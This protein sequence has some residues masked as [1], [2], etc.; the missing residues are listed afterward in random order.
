MNAVAATSL[1][2]RPS[3]PGWTPL[4][5]LA[6]AN[7]ARTQMAWI[8]PQFDAETINR[9]GDEIRAAGS[10][11][12]PKTLEIV[13]NWRMAHAFPL[14]TVKASLRNNCF[15]VDKR[16]AVVSRIKRFQTIRQKLRRI[17]KLTL[18]EMQDLGGAR[19]IF[20][21]CASIDRLLAFYEPAAMR[22]AGYLS[23]VIRCNNYIN[24]PK[25]DGYR[26][27][28]LIFRYKGTKPV[29]DGLF[30]EAQVR[31]QM[32][33]AWATTVEI[34]ETILKQR[35]RTSQ[36]DASWK[37]FLAL[38][39]TAIALEEKRPPVPETPPS[40]DEIRRDILRI[41]ASIHVKG[42]LRGV[43]NAIT[44]APKSGTGSTWTVLDMRPEEDKTSVFAFPRDSFAQ[45]ARKLAD[46]EKAISSGEVEDPGANAVL[47][48]VPS[49]EALRETY[50]NYYLDAGAFLTLFDRLILQQPPAGPG[51]SISPTAR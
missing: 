20:P 40:M 51:A 44:K 35:L 18:Y 6:A 3:S 47:V 14:N 15:R 27:V 36:G 22:R 24:E 45:A 16:A 21:D 23:E 30:I 4:A 19:A 12:D 48:S 38:M 46:V 11:L 1:P 25:K 13:Y 17:P 5:E 43:I 37:R 39:S 29:W 49:I 33:H 10:H 2:I 8:R 34:L 32:Q 9:A 7:E 41:D 42:T 26:S 28:H 50:P 31:S